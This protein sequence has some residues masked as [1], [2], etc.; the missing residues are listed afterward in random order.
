MNR[1]T[2]GT[3]KLYRFGD[4]RGRQV[5]DEGGEKVGTVQDV[6]LDAEGQEVRYL[7]VRAGGV[8]G[9]DGRML[10]IPPHVVEGISEDRVTLNEGRQK[11]IEEPK[12]SPGHILESHDR[13]AISRHFGGPLL[14]RG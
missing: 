3:P 4:L 10:L 11:V 12:F 1:T 8:L 6:F 13:Q 7:D 2:Q 9:L 14:S 5:L